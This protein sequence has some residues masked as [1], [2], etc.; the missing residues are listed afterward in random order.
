MMTGSWPHIG[1]SACQDLGRCGPLHCLP[2]HWEFS[3]AAEPL[4]SFPLWI[5][6][7]IVEWDAWRHAVAGL[8]GEEQVRRQ[9]TAD[10]AA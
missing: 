4:L 2:C 5:Q 1:G 6:A 10:E 8:K 7:S 3:A 9:R